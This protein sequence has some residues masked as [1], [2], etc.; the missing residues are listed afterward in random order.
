MKTISKHMRTTDNDELEYSYNAAAPLFR[1]PPYPTLEGIQST[2]DF[3]AEKEP[4]AKQAHP[5][6]FV[7]NS[8]LDEL[9]KTSADIP[10]K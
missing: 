8:L 5:K 7:D 3:L 2:L 4:K 9:V 1:A 10:K 6:D